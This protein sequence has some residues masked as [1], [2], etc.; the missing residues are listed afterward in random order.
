[1]NVF[2][3]R[4]YMAHD[5]DELDKSKFYEKSY[6]ME[7]S[8]LVI[9]G[10]FCVADDTIYNRTH[11]MD[12]KSSKIRKLEKDCSMN[13]VAQGCPTRGPRS[14]HLSHDRHELLLR[15]YVYANLW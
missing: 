2:G 9:Q 14:D 13:T 8:V 6:E 7:K 1:M 11:L 5:I 3:K 12:L 15:I 10:N 4:H